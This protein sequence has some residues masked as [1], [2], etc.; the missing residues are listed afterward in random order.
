[1]WVL[2]FSIIVAFIMHIDAVLVDPHETPR[3]SMEATKQGLIIVF[4]IWILKISTQ[5]YIYA[6]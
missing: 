3:T 6:L 4:K 1:M 5:H 2:N